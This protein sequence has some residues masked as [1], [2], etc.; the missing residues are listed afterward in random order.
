MGK[1]LFLKFKIATF[2]YSKIQNDLLVSFFS[3]T[4]NLW[5]ELDQYRKSF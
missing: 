3:S 1:L 4:F 2:I 5:N